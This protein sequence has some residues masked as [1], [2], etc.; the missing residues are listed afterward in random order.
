[1]QHRPKFNGVYIAV[2][3]ALAL[4]AFNLWTTFS[5][6]SSGV[7]MPY[8]KVVDYF[9][10]NQVVGFEMDLNTGNLR[11]ALKEG[12]VPLPEGVKEQQLARARGA[13]S[14]AELEALV[15]EL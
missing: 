7:S 3:L 12:E 4:L 5:T 13:R 11:L 8:S 9:E 14:R 15:R 6:A 2:L 1:M 10:A